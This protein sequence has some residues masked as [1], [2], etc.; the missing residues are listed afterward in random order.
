MKSASQLIALPILCA[1]GNLLGPP[2]THAQDLS[3]LAGT[4]EIAFRQI[5]TEGSLNGCSLVFK[6]SALDD[7][8]KNGRPVILSGNVTF[9]AQKKEKTMVMALKLGLLDVFGQNVQWE[10]PNFAYLMTQQGS[11]AKGMIT[12]SGTDTPGYRLFVY[13]IDDQGF[14]VM[15]NLIEE[16]AVIIGFNRKKGGVDVLAPL[17]LTVSNT[18]QR[19]GKFDRKHSTEMIES[20]SKC[21]SELSKYLQ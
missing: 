10:E 18:S 7:A 3:L 11:T 8:Y 2:E 12:E 15:K 21:L 13:Q 1:L 6:A 9:Y 5:L 16:H 19:N 17:D 14:L 4:Y 20:F